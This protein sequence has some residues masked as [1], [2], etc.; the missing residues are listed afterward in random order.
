M[1][2]IVTQA[3]ADGKL[4]KDQGDFMVERVEN[5]QGRM[6]FGRGRGKGPG[7]GRGNCGG[8]R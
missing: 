3:V 6:G 1:K 5:G 8:F 2:D 7:F 4:T